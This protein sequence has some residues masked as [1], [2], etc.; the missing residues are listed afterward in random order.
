MRSIG[1]AL[2]FVGVTGQA[3]GQSSA[4]AGYVG[5]GVTVAWQPEEFSDGHYMLVS[6]LGGVSA[7]GHFQAGVHLRKAFSLSGELSV[8]GSVGGERI[9]LAP[10]GLTEGSVRHR[11]TVISAVGRWHLESSAF[12]IQPLGGVSWVRTHTESASVLR[13]FN[14][15]LP[16]E[17]MERSAESETRVGI[18]GGVDVVG[19]LSRRFGVAPFFRVHWVRRPEAPQERF[20]GLPS[21]IYRGGVLL[22]VRWW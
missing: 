10:G 6:T 20:A 14:P 18:T 17:P 5:G 2:L 7:G 13:S 3:F 15:S 9:Q 16:P 21:V 19:R 4:D 8:P 22:V 12:T 1:L 11:E